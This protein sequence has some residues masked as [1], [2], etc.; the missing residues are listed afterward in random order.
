MLRKLVTALVCDSRRRL[1]VSNPALS[2]MA[3][4]N[5]GAKMLN[6]RRVRER[7][8]RGEEVAA[9]LPALLSMR[10]REAAEVVAR[11]RDDLDGYID[12]GGVH[13]ELNP[14]TAGNGSLPEHRAA[15]KR[16]QIGA[17]L[18]W[19]DSLLAPGATCVDFCAGSGHLGLVVAAARP[20]C[21][22]VI[23]EKKK[24]H[25]ELAEKRI[26]IAGLANARVVCCQVSDFEKA[27]D[28]GV[29]LHACGPAT[30]LIH[31]L[32]LARRAAYVLAPC[33][34]GF[35]ARALDKYRERSLLTTYWSEST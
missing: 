4:H 18:S 5:T 35:I 31:S 33:C 13:P 21:Q 32:C 16:M 6:A 14:S 15:R 30:D 1:A 12:W 2:E 8:R 27:F 17:M 11:S 26:T 19:V 10:G 28:V 29:G 22:V 20:D 25:C 24:L 34:Y 3:P 23:L 7:K 9:V